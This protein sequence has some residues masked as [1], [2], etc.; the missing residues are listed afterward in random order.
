MEIDSELARGSVRRD[1]AAVEPDDDERLGNRLENFLAKTV[2]PQSL[3]SHP[4]IL[5]GRTVR[6]HRCGAQMCL[7]VFA[8]RGITVL[9]MR[10]GG[11]A[12]R[13]SRTVAT[14]RGSRR[15]LASGRP[16]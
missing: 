12:R 14:C 13:Y 2:V 16:G 8:R 3:G 1:R 6:A 11:R 5:A 9:P 4:L 10:A 7:G 15:R